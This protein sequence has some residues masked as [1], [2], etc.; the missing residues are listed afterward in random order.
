MV[1]EKIEIRRRFFCKLYNDSILGLGL[2]VKFF[3]I[4]VF[5]YFSCLN[6]LANIIR[7][8][9]YS[10]TIPISKYSNTI[11]I[12]KYS[13]T[14]VFEHWS[15]RILKYSNTHVFEYYSNIKVFEYSCIRIVWCEL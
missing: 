1:L 5:E 3:S 2:F 11:R 10:N 6:Y 8:S 15:I 4:R 14:G 12:L 13:N 9:K 7:I